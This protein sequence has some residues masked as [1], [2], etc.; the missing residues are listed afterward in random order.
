MAQCALCERNS[1]EISRALG[2]C[3]ACIRHQPQAAL[4]IALQAHRQSRFEFGL[5]P[6]PPDSP[7]GLSCNVCV[8]RCRM[9]EGEMGYCGLRRNRN[10]RL[11]GVSSTAAKLSWYHD[12]LPTNCVASWVCPGGTGAGHPQFAYRHGAETGS[13]NLAVFFQAC[14]FNCLFC[15]NWHFRH[16]TLTAPYH[17]VE[18][19]VSDADE[20]TSCICYFGGDPA[21]QMRFAI[22]AS[23][24]ASENAG[25]RILRICWETNGSVHPDLLNEVLEIAIDSGGCVKFDLK[26]RDPSLHVALTGITNQRTLDN[27]AR[28]AQKI[29]R[30]PVPPLLIASTLLVP[31][32]IDAQEVAAIAGFI[33]G[34]NPDIPYSLLAFH[35]QFFMSDMP[36]TSKTLADQ[37]LRAARDA[38]LKNVRLGNV[39]LLV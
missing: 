23:K 7:G 15:Q 27:F 35:P 26:T 17:T 21:P 20:R 36:L 13:K 11:V 4:E 25:G 38:G 22:K 37:C 6:S 5:P 18:E 1:V 16:E 29:G 3:L 12:P 33:A 14:S 19:L 10:G 28:A 9:A 39:H 8:N 2:V 32:Y 30:R 34:L 24:Q 31:G